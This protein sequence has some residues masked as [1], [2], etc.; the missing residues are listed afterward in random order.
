MLAAGTEFCVTVS[1]AVSLVA[2]PNAFRHDDVE[3]R[4]AVSEL[5]VGARV[6]R[7]GRARD[8]SCRCVA[9]DRRA[10]RSRWR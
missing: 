10:A 9:I 2:E 8:R 1:C 6:A 7:T 5:R 4:A 3:E